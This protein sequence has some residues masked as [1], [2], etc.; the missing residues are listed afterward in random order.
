MSDYAKTKCS[1]HAT[2]VYYFE[3]MLLLILALWLIKWLFASL[4]QSSN[5][6]D[7]DVFSGGFYH[8]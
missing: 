3:S 4:P 8:E 7:N 6:L 1:L 5:H 2:N